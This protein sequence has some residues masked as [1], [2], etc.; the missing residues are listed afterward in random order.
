M[1]FADNDWFNFDINYNTP[2]ADLQFI[3]VNFHFET[4]VDSK[5]SGLYSGSIFAEIYLPGRE[6]TAYHWLFS[7]EEVRKSYMTN[8]VNITKEEEDNK[9][10]LP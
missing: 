9:S 6:V 4:N 5:A 10:Q 8:L 7:E 3:F 2:E 1:K